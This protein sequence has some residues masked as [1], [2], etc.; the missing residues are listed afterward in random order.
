[1]R[2]TLPVVLAALLPVGFAACSS[3][4]AVGEGT[5]MNDLKGTAPVANL[6]D[7]DVTA[8]TGEP[9]NLREY[10]GKVVLVVNVASRCGLTPQYEELQALYEERKDL[11]LVVLGFPANDF[12]GQEPGTNEEIYEFCSVNFGVTF[13][14]FEKIVVTGEDAHPL[15]QDL[16][17][18]SEAPSWNF[19]KY[20]IA[21][22]GQFI[23]RFD[24]RTSPSSDELVS[25]IDAA[26][27]ALN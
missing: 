16:A 8:I 20:L 7:R 22:D 25:A 21:P 15:F 27:T 6:L 5:P 18:K 10:E 17:S 11:G 24:P 1:M 14:M 4:Q 13:P 9:V 12:L 23:A 3:N 26:L 2:R 19:T